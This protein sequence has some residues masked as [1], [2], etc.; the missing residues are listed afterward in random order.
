MMQ[1]ADILRGGW[2]AD[3]LEA[4]EEVKMDSDR[5]EPQSRGLA[6]GGR[7]HDHGVKPPSMIS[8]D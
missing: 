5:H 1:T 6:A 8:S 4:A 2:F 7:E 3:V